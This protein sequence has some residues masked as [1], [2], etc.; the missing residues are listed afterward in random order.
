MLR[1]LTQLTAALTLALALGMLAVSPAPHPTRDALL[2]AAPALLS[3]LVWGVAAT[4]LGGAL[5][6]RARLATAF[7]LGA[8]A[9]GLALLPLGMLGLLQPGILGAVAV[10]ASAAWLRRPVIDLPELPAGA[11]GWAV[12]VG[13]PAF[14]VALGPPIDT[15]EVYQHLALPSRM[16]MEGGL[17]GGL[18]SPDG[19]RPLPIHLL[20]T[21]AMAL[22]GEGAPKLLHL[23]W[24]GLLL[25]HVFDTGRRWMGRGAGA[26]AALALLGSYSVVRE[27][28]LAYNNLPVALW[29]LLSLEAALEDRRLRAA[30]LAGMALAGKYTAAPVV[31]GIY[32][33]IWLRRALAGRGLVGA[34]PEM[35]GLTALALAFVAPWWLRN[36]LEGL[37]P[38]F[39]Y[40]GW[41][42]AERFVFAYVERYGLGRD[43]AAMWM[44]PWNLSV[45][46]ETTSYV[47][48]GRVTPAVLLCVPGMVLA[49]LRGD[50]L[51]HPVL[52]VSLVAFIGWAMG[53]HWLRYLLP[54]A[55]VIALAAGGGFVALP[56]WGKAV[57][58]L[59]WLAALPANLG[60]WLSDV[61]TL[62]PV[63]LGEGDRDALMDARVPGN[64]AARWINTHAPPDARVALL[65]S[66]P[67][68]G[69]E[70]SN[71][72][73][74]VEDHVPTR[75][76]LFS[77]GDQSLA[78]LRA[79]GVTHVLAGKVHFIR[80]SYPFLDE[81]TFEEQ[82]VAAEAQL[83]ALLLAEATLVFE[84]GR[85]GVWRL[86][87]P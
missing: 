25:V 42:D 9:L 66:W 30:V 16:L 15:D 73:G 46:A 23:A 65:F 34:I 31:V 63:A 14:I 70:R 61:V 36:A 21:G 33:V 83:D 18:L 54:A 40:A 13:A 28:G 77:R 76:L 52:A 22:G 5:L 69:L 59:A 85:Y 11:W 56:R 51:I 38:L 6:G 20:Y 60:P 45:H 39:P 10:L 79:Q 84:S 72:L 71:V 17:V 67:I 41:P 74:S 1:V 50:N 62:A 48:L 2:R 7:A 49:A 37:H 75:H 8:G 53:P 58:L 27:L 81:E 78:W 3:A 29:A 55:P 57:V 43:W 87:E 19:S 4:G 35:A 86:N 82:F 26:L 68:A 64:D 24:A 12:A 47:F 80:K 44:L 32:L